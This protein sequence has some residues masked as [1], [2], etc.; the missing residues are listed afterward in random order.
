MHDAALSP[1][2][3]TSQEVNLVR[4]VAIALVAGSERIQDLHGC[5]RYREGNVYA[6]SK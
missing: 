6:Y 1:P 2:S 5:C 3:V 4:Q